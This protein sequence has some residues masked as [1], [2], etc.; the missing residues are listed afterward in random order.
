MKKLSYRIKYEKVV[1]SPSL[2]L[3]VAGFYRQYLLILPLPHFAPLFVPVSNSRKWISKTSYLSHPENL[4]RKAIR[5]SK[6]LRIP[7]ELRSGE[8]LGNFV[9]R[10]GKKLLR[11]YIEKWSRVSNWNEISLIP[12]KTGAMEITTSNWLKVLK[13]ID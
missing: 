12:F 5:S 7:P 9:F 6:N 8:I 13:Q 10:S 2:S 1:I 11:S 4:I 3:P